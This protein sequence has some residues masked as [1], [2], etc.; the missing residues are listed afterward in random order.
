MEGL[1]RLDRPVDQPVRRRLS[2]LLPRSAKSGNDRVSS[3][4]NSF[5]RAVGTGIS[6]DVET[7]IERARRLEVPAE[8]KRWTPPDIPDDEIPF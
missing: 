7:A 6:A 8:P 1:A 3:A 2:D 5:A 4:S